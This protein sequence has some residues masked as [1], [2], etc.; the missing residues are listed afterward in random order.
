MSALR[1]A[2]G[3]TGR[4]V[5]VK[6]EGCYHGHADALLVK[7]G[8][9]L[10]TFG[11]PTS[12]GVPEAVV[13]HTLVLEYNNVAALDEAFARHGSDDRLRDDRADRRQ[14]ELRPRQRAVHAAAARA[15]HARTAPCS[16]STR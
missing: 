15:V 11:H 3:A 14:H 12:A 8:S 1:L 6:F 5:I 10:A 4:N 16:S 7:A 13:Q 9:G 2:R